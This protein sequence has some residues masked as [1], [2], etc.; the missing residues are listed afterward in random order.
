MFVPRTL[1]RREIPH[2]RLTENPS[3]YGFVVRERGEWIEYVSYRT[4]A[5]LVH[6]YPDTHERSAGRR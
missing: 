5:H 1:K 3:L 6:P 2:L 4:A